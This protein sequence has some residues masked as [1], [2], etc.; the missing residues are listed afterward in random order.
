[1]SGLAADRRSAFFHAQTEVTIANRRRGTQTSM[2]LYGRFSPPSS[3]RSKLRTLPRRGMRLLLPR[4][5][6]YTLC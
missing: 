3:V 1:M 6:R 2:Q 5:A 4:G